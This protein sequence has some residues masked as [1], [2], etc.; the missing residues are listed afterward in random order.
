VSVPAAVILPTDFHDRNRKA[1][2]KFP[3]KYTAVQKVWKD[4]SKLRVDKIQEM[5]TTIHFRS[6]A[7]YYAT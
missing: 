4:T 2:K 3:R 5:P 1:G 6:L 7:L